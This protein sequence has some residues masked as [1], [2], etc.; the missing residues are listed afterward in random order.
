MGTVTTDVL[1]AEDVWGE[2]FARL[3][4]RYRV[5]HEPELWDSRAALLAQAARSRA[6]VVRNRTRVDAGLLDNAPHLQVVARAGAGLDNIDVAAAEARGVVVVAA[7]GANAISVAEHTLA[8]ALALARSIPAHDRAV[9]AGRWERNPGT[10]LYGRTWGLLGVGAT[11]L[12][13]ARLVGCLGMRVL[14]Y[15]TQVAADDAAVT[16]AG[17]VLVPLDRVASDADVVSVHLPATTET[18]GMVGSEFLARMRPGSLLINVGRG[19]V[20]DEAA[21][22]RALRDGP[23]AGAGLDVR[24]AEPPELGALDQLPNVV[25]TPHVAGLTD[26]AQQR[27]LEMLAGALDALLSGGEARDVAGRLRSLRA[28]G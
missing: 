24:A 27:V 22:A 16:D 25:L 9:R 26:Q 11:G 5:T 3:A 12:A 13:V 7:P 8:L 2:P 23:L 4:R 14:G 21:L 20:V 15:D 6:L 17:V 28:V 10:E 1:V 18:R 19:E